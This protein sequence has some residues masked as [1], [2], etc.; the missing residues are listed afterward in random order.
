MS[1]DNFKSHK[2]PGFHPSLEDTFFTK[3]QSGGGKPAVLGLRRIVISF[4]GSVF[5]LNV[6]F[7]RVD[8]WLGRDDERSSALRTISLLWY[9]C[10]GVS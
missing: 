7:E 2:N 6:F 1:Y 4:F 3:T 8:C 9:F 10:F 5:M